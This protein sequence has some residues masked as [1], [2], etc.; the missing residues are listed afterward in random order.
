MINISIC[1]IIDTHT[2]AHTCKRND[3]IIFR[4]CAQVPICV[5]LYVDGALMGFIL[6]D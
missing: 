4:R 5:C 3:F 6:L 2:H 1:I